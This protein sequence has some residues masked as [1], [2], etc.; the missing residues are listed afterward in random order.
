MKSRISSF[1]I[2]KELWRKQT[3]LFALTC[4]M[5]FILCTIPG[6]LTMNLVSSET[7]KKDFLDLFASVPQNYGPSVVLSL[8]V[9]VTIFVGT[10]AGMN[11]FSYLHSKTKVDFYHGMP[12][13]R[14]RLY[15]IQAGICLVDY[16]LPAVVFINLLL[17]IGT[18]RGIASGAAWMAAWEMILAGLALL[19]VCYAMACLATLLTGRLIVAILG[20]GTFM[21]LGPLTAA[22]KEGWLT[23]FMATYDSPVSLADQPLWKF[24]P[25]AYPW[26]AMLA[27]DEKALFISFAAGFVLFWINLLIYRKRPSEAAG[28]S[29]A[30]ALPAA[31]IQIILTITA[32]LLLGLFFGTIAPSFSRGWFIFGLIFGWL[33]AYAVI[34]MIY[35]PSFRKL[36]SGKR[37]L[38]VSGILIC[39][40]AV[41]S[42]FGMKRYERM[43][44]TQDSIRDIGVFD[45]ASMENYSRSHDILE[46]MKLPAD[47]RVYGFLTKLASECDLSEADDES[48]NY[49]TIQV[50]VTEK[51]GKKMYRRYRIETEKIKE[52]YA[53]LYAYPEFKSFLYPSLNQKAEALESLDFVLDSA[54]FS[55]YADLDM[56]KKQELFRALQED[57]KNM[58]PET[59]SQEI[60]IAQIDCVVKNVDEASSY[61]YGDFNDS[62]LVYPSFTKTLALLKKNGI[63]LPDFRKGVREIRIYDPDKVDENGNLTSEQ[64]YTDKEEIEKLLP[65]IIPTAYDTLWVDTDSTR[66]VE[67][68]YQDGT[69]V[70]CTFLE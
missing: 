60:P 23:T 42:L 1:R 45:G 37:R 32:S 50:R 3:W 28:R 29:M 4:L 41:F 5:Y 68:H 14:T 31:V 70:D 34:Q 62:I 35:V 36:A 16:L 64:V 40:I 67:I 24:S 10:V 38:L 8:F 15:L 13:S 66:N 59:V 47:E 69:S 20:V 39:L 55:V 65:D 22:L 58:S 19:T 49:L 17:L 27:M 52:E 54:M 57:V 12:V 21:V 9:V 11:A 46:E 30:F 61:Y 6:M 26:Q 7:M 56:R 33:L 25:F 63:T 44:P 18:V 48:K 53:W 2:A 43:V 51:N